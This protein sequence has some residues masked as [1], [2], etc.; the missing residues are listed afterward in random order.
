M[1]CQEP[2][3]QLKQADKMKK[4]SLEYRGTKKEA[5]PKGAASFSSIA[6]QFAVS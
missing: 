4:N 2:K 5:N 6:R 3:L 1:L